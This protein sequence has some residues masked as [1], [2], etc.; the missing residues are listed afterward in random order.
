M[1]HNHLRDLLIKQI[2]IDSNSTAR[3]FDKQS[4]N[5]NT[6]GL[7]VN[8]NVDITGSLKTEAGFSYQTSEDQ[9][10]KDLEVAYSPKYVAQVKLSYEIDKHIFAISGRFI[11]SMET[12]YDPA[13]DNGDGTFGARIGEKAAAY[14]VF[15][16][17]YRAN[18]FFNHMYF[19]FRITN[20]LN[21]TIRYPNNPVNSALLDR[22]T[23]GAER[24]MIGTVGWKY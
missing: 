17:N 18:D 13:I 8:L 21:E 1:Y 16:V 19:D 6:T 3:E 7:E 11:D 5:I 20:L 15:D 24:N 10:N 2:E 22:G 9:N 4:G 23:L 14:Q 12:Y